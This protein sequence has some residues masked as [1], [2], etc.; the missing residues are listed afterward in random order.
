M[1]ENEGQ[2]GKNGNRIL[3]RLASIKISEQ[4]KSQIS[5]K[6]GVPYVR[7]P[8]YESTAEIKPSVLENVRNLFKTW[9]DKTYRMRESQ[10]KAKRQKQLLNEEQ[11]MR[12]KLEYHFM[13]PFEKYKRGRKPWKLA[14]QILKIIIVTIQVGLL[15]SYQLFLCFFVNG[16][17]GTAKWNVRLMKQ[18]LV[19]KYIQSRGAQVNSFIR[20][21]NHYLK[22]ALKCFTIFYV[23]DFML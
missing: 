7:Y 16:M 21:K 9:R 17:L 3:K 8:S 2:D 4:E 5:P 15:S 11:K 13:T 23:Y 18:F 14:I 19:D 6:N 12:R 1:D 22:N 20:L 10:L